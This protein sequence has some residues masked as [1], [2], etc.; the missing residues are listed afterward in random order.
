MPGQLS[1]FNEAEV[2][3]E[4]TPDDEFAERV[5]KT[6]KK[7]PSLEDQFKGIPVRKVV[8]D[9]ISGGQCCILPIS[10]EQ[11]QNEVYKGQEYLGVYPYLV[12]VSCYLLFK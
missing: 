5:V 9:G 8:F 10:K 4:N 12:C 11:T 2:E 6:R 7:K 3:N 1:L